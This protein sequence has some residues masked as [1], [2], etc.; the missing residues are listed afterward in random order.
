[1]T[2]VARPPSVQ[3]LADRRRV[4][5]AGEHP[6][7]RLDRARASR[8]TRGSSPLRTAQPSLR[9]IR[10]TTPLTSASWSR[11]SMPCRPRWSADTLVTTE[12][13]LRVSPMPLSRMPP[14]AVSVT[15]SCDLRVREHPAGAR[16]ARVVPGLDQLAVDVDAV[17]VRPADQPAVG[18]GDVRDHPRRRGLAVGAGHRDHRHPR[19][20]RV[21]RGAGLRRGH[22]RGRRRSPPSST[23]P[24]GTASS[25]SATAVPIT[26]A[27]G[28]GAATGRPRR[29]GAGRWSAAPGRRAGSSPTRSRSRAPAGRPRAARTAAGTRSRAPRGARSAARSAARTARAVSSGTAASPPMSRVSLIAARGK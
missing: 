1:M 13:S 17:G 2:V 5:V 29:S 19:R 25:T 12:T 20:D 28:R 9:V 21:R 11:V 23:S 24:P 18:A 4:R 22:P 15:A 8:S 16:R 6:R 14:R 3:H 27:R 10:G 26:C 7:L